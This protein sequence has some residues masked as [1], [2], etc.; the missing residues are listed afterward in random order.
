MM[1]LFLGGLPRRSGLAALLVCLGVMLAANP[2]FAV[3]ERVVDVRIAGNLRTGEDTVRSLA[4]I[5][6]GD[7]L[8][9]DTLAAVR[10]RLN[11]VGLFADVN[12]WW[13]NYGGGV[14][15]NILVKDKFPW[16]PVPTGSWSANNKSLGLLFVHGNLFGRGK[17]M[18]VGGKLANLDSG[19]LLAYRDPALFSSWVFWEMKVI[20]QRQI[21]PEYSIY[22]RAP[23]SPWRQTTLDAY[24]I[25]P[26]LG[27]AWFRRVKTQVSW[28][29]DKVVYQEKGLKVLDPVTGNPEPLDPVNQATTR[30]GYMG[31]GRAAVAFDWRAREFAVMRGSALGGSLDFG[32]PAFGGDFRFW[33]ASAF[34]EQGF[35][36]LRRHNFIYAAGGTLGH[37]LPIW[38]DTVAGGPGLRGYLGQQF[39][40]DSQLFAKVEYHFPLFSLGSL[41]VRGVTFYDAAAIWFR[42]LPTETNAAGYLV[43]QGGDMRTFN[44]A[45]QVKGFDANRNFHHDV[46]AGLRFFLR[47]VA[48]PLVGFDGG[49]SLES[50]DWRFLLIVGA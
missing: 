46:G 39:R 11:T 15:V 44:P 10:E 1:L 42:S 3:G 2:A 35:R 22:D 33:R 32:G 41:D 20:A 28:R 6:I 37:N 47:S 26:A 49:L 29:F 34:W 31:L 5:R 13:E 4:G 24:G 36:I 9:A 43:R 50:H 14:R 40:G 48:V 45:F 19:L 30:G 18:V 38:W 23:T 21:I 17:Q 7:T 27:V 12:V 16:A 25:E 8:E